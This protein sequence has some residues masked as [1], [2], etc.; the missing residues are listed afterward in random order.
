[1]AGS[2]HNIASNETT[3]TYSTPFAPADNHIYINVDAVN[4]SGGTSIINATIAG[5]RIDEASGISSSTS[6]VIQ[7][8][9]AGPAAYQSLNKWYY[10]SSITL[11][12]DTGSIDFILYDI[13][14][15]GYVDFLNNDVTITGYR[16]EALGD[17][18]G[19]TSDIGVE[20]I[21]VSQS[22]S[23]TTLTD[24]ENISV[25]GDGGLGNGEV[26][27]SLRSGAHDR[28]FTM[29]FGTDIWPRNV[30]F[31][32]KQTD[33]NSYFTN[34]ENFIEGTNDGGLIV[35]LTSSAFGG[36]NGPRYATIFIY[37]TE[38]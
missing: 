17:F 4:I 3:L 24:I 23:T 14:T 20:L 28:S 5:K 11:T 16:F 38:S 27:D 29:P 6:E 8:S 36:T 7:I 21:A 33:F 22:G 37:Y 30:N 34:N 1:M 2:K 10:V 31:V 15:L 18:D 35:K 13:D 12:P 32:F 19:S 26:I 9:V 25:D